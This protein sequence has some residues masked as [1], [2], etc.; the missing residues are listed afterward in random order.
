[1]VIACLGW[2]SLVWDPR[3][4]PVQGRWFEDGPML[5]VEFARQSSDE[6]LTL[7][8]VPKG[9]PVRT[10]WAP[11]S[12][13][14]VAIAR[15]ALRKREGILEKNRE[16]HIAV[17]STPDENCDP[18]SISAWARGLNIDAVVWTALPPRFDGKDGR[19]PSPDEAVD[20]LRK[21][22]HEQRRH[23]ERYIR[24][25]PRQVDTPYRRRFELEFGWT[26]VGGAP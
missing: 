25:T 1:M 23:A 8:I 21:L 4:L 7:V 22:P 6:R 16:K 19:V 26:P 20:Y 2:G 3:E 11:F 24:M 17:W 5:S 13:E 10:L 14:T 15:E 9:T 18:P 12:V